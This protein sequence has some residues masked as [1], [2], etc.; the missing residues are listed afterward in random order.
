MI[1]SGYTDIRL[2][3]DEQDTLYRFYMLY[4]SSVCTHFS[5]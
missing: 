1:L 3:F 2:G 4:T 5:K